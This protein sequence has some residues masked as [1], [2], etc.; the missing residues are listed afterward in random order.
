MP[1]AGNLLLSLGASVIRT[2]DAGALAYFPSNLSN[3]VPTPETVQGGLDQIANSNGVGFTPIVVLSPTITSLSTFNLNFMRLGKM[4]MCTFVIVANTSIAAPITCSILFS[5]PIART[6]LNF[7]DIREANGSFTIAGI[8][9][10][11][12]TG[13]YT[14]LNANT[15]TQQISLQWD[16][17]GVGHP[18]TIQVSGSFSYSL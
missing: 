18:T 10:S 7:V 17:N 16:Q 13:T 11:N 2:S 12:A 9:A 14:Q 8:P 3:W 5:L 1:Q 15:G 4:I 6:S